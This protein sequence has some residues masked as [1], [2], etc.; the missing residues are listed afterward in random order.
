MYNL[1]ALLS[2]LLHPVERDS[3]ETNDE[4]DGLDARPGQES[5]SR[6]WQSRQWL[7]PAPGGGS[8]FSRRT[9]VAS[10][11][12]NVLLITIDTLRA[13]ALGA[14]GNASAATPWMDRLA[15]GGVRFRTARAH[16]VLTLPSHAN[17]LTG[18]LPP[19]HGVRDNAGFRLA[20]GE[21]TL[22]TRLKARELSH[23]RLHQRVPARL[24][25]WPVPRF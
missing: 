6:S 18:R 10:L 1:N 15:A 22:A 25:V 5:R 23:R 4:A 12:R 24:A 16:N 13:D 17:I 14:Y 19:D 9:I 3:E 21:A 2:R 8:S 11:P 7:P 20:G